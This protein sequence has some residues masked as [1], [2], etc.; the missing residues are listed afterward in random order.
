MKRSL[1]LM[2][3]C[4]A[5]I[6]SLSMCK[7]TIEKKAQEQAMD[8]I[9]NGEWIVEQYFEGSNNISN[10]FLNY[11]FKFNSDGTVK[12]TINTTST[13]GTWAANVSDYTITSNFP[14][15]DDP[16]KKLNGVWKIKDSDYD[17][18]KAEMTTTS[19]TNT[20]YLRKK[21]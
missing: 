9:T 18:V 20:L 19:G 2:A 21:T 12:G 3:G 10:Q 14:S 6:V 15:A 1:P 13:N 7:K 4:L 17:Y 16:I 11:T 8:V 5:L